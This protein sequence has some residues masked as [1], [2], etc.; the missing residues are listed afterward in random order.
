MRYS[1]QFLS[2]VLDTDFSCRVCGV[3][4]VLETWAFYDDDDD[5]TVPPLMSRFHCCPVDATHRRAGAV[6]GRRRS[7]HQS[8]G[9]LAHGRGPRDIS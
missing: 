4:A 3:P 8:A 6:R 1:G 5:I 2:A 9:I 7:R